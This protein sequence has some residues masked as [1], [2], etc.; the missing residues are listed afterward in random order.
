MDRNEK[1]IGIL[2]LVSTVSFA[3]LP[4]VVAFSGPSEVARILMRV[5][6]LSW[7]TAE[8]YAALIIDAALA[9]TLTFATLQFILAV[10]SAGTVSL[11]WSAISLGLRYVL[12]VYGRR[13]AM[14]W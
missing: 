12:K 7:P 4:E 10:L 1:I 13:A 11:I 3:I 9:G 14:L 5:A 2:L 6:G 8:H